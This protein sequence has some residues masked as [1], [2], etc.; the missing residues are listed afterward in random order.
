MPRLFSRGILFFLSDQ[1]SDELDLADLNGV[2]AFLAINYFKLN[3]VILTNRHTVQ[4]GNMNENFTTIGV[5]NDKAEA[6]ALVEKLN[7]TCLHKFGIN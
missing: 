1:R 4:A 6:F 2:E 5:I 3:P 7:H